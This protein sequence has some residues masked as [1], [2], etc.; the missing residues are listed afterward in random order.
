MDHKAYQNLIYGLLSAQR[1]Q[2]EEAIE[3]LKT[4]AKNIYIFGAGVA[5]KLIQKN[6]MNFDISVYRFVDNSPQKIGTAVESI[7]VISFQELAKSYEP[8]TIIIG[9]VAYHDEIVKQCLEGGIPLSD[10]CFADFLHYDK[11]EITRSYFLENIDVICNIYSH[12][13]D[14]ESKDLFITNLLYQFTRDRLNYCVKMSP[15][16][17]QYYEPDIMHL[18]NNEVYFDCGAKD[19]DTA[20]A[21]RQACKGKY[22]KIVTFEPDEENFDQMQ[23]NLADVPNVICVNA[24]VGE[25]EATLAFNGNVGGHSS[26]QKTGKSLAK[27]VPLD[28]YIN[29]NPTLIKMDIE[30]FELSALMGAQAILRKHRPKLAICVYHK[31]CDIVELPKYI[32][33]QRED[34]RIYFRLYRNF[35]HDLVCYFV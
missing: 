5:G 15:L 11:K 1:D 29:E 17:K 26:F 25:T 30:G 33:E 31:P 7:P 8:K 20:L 10:I 28:R 14:D 21:F 18:G 2:A 24:G 35:G 6:L 4:T 13:A 16:S 12:C 9:T 34:Y 27:I 19:G 3:S 23:K 22:K 32:L